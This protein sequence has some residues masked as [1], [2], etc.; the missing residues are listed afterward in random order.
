MVFKTYK[1]PNK[2]NTHNHRTRTHKR[3]Y[4]SDMR[5]DQ[6]QVIAQPDWSLLDGYIHDEKRIIINELKENAKSRRFNRSDLL[7]AKSAKHLNS[8]KP[9][10]PYRTDKDIKGLLNTYVF[11]HLGQRKL[12][13][14]ELYML[15]RYLK[16]Y[17]DKAVMVYAGAAAGIHF[18]YLSKIFPNVDMHLYDPADFAIKPTARIHIYNEFFTDDVARSWT[19]GGEM[20][21]KY[22]G[23]H[24]FLC[25]IRVSITGM[26]DDEREA[27]VNEDMTRQENWVKIIRPQYISMLKFRPPYN[28]PKLSYLNGEILWQT[29]PPKSSG[30]TRLLITTADIEAGPVKYDVLKY[31]NICYQHNIINRAFIRYNDL[32]LFN[33]VNGYD[34]CWDCRAEAETWKLYLEMDNKNMSYT[35]M[36]NKIAKYMNEASTGTQRRLLGPISLHGRYNKN[37]LSS[38]WLNG[39][40]NKLRNMDKDYII[41]YYLDRKENLY[42]DAGVIGYL[43]M[44]DKKPDKTR[45]TSTNITKNLKIKKSKSSKTNKPSK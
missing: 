33:R 19:A 39:M 5:Q 36:I 22:G 9:P 44:R 29:W 13:I 34:G 23:C 8:M 18:P 28:E 12:F 32:Q 11:A 45:K 31:E 43:K 35:A 42:K 21:K 40:Q 10:L 20:Y 24:F 25:D 4:G 38:G 7:L 2:L 26:P 17:Q 14:T 16:S 41:K 1:N 37:I 30:E 27:I 6:Y 3:R 15:S